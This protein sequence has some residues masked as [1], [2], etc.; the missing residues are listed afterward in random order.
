MHFCYHFPVF[1]SVF[2]RYFGCE[3]Q[4]TCVLCLSV[5]CCLLSL[6]AGKTDDKIIDKPSQN[7]LCRA[8]R[9]NSATTQNFTK[10]KIL[11]Q[12]STQT[13]M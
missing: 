4:L 7:E 3:M 8:C 2:Q 12:T 11:T 6:D 13:F 1:V 9:R 10:I 5:A